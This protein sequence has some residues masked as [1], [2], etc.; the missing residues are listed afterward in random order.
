MNKLINKITHWIIADIKDS[1]NQFKYQVNNFSSLEA[2]RLAENK[3]D[4]R[5]Y[6][7]KNRPREQE[8][9]GSGAFANEMI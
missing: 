7:D 1:V 6:F 9:T 8:K 3:Q 4:M 2:A 5:W